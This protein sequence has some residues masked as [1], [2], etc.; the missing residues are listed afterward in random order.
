MDPHPLDLLWRVS[1]MQAQI[2]LTLAIVRHYQRR[3]PPQPP[4]LWLRLPRRKPLYQLGPPL[5][6]PRA[7]PWP[8]AFPLMLVRP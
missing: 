3:K 1:G 4:R 6:H 8:E 7:C 2:L 5:T